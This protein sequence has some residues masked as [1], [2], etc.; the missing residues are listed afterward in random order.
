M[1]TLSGTLLAK[2]S[3]DDA[4]LTNQCEPEPGGPGGKQRY[5]GRGVTRLEVNTNSLSKTQHD[6]IEGLVTTDLEDG[7]GHRGG[8]CHGQH[9]LRGRGVVQGGDGGPLIHDAS[10]NIES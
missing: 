6:I 4:L 7:A 1:S 8:R 2:D 9:G 3:Y 5:R 10:V